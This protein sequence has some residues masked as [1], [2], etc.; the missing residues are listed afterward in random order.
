M[1]TDDATAAYM[2]DRDSE[3]AVDEGGHRIAKLPDGQEIHAWT[4]PCHLMFVRAGS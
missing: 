3:R 2:A 1:N 4:C